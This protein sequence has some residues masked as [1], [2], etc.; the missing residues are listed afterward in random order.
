MREKEREKEREREKTSEREF[1]DITNGVPIIYYS[2]DYTWVTHYTE[3][4][5]Y[6]GYPLSIVKSIHGLPSI[7]KRFVFCV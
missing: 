4:R 2:K 6:T 1:W 3:K 5:L 7:N